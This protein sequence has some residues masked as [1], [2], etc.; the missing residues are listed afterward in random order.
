MM[1]KMFKM[2]GKQKTSVAKMRKIN[3]VEY[4]NRYLRTHPYQQ[5]MEKVEG[6]INFLIAAR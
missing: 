4:I 3:L 1:F 2:Y 6:T 5:Q